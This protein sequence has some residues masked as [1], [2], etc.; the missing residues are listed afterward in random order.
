M[1]RPSHPV[2][3]AVMRTALAAALA[4]AG[5]VAWHGLAQRSGAGADAARA[6]S[7]GAAAPPPM[8][9]PVA[10]AQL[11]D[12]PETAEFT[13]HLAAVRSVE[14]RPRVGGVIEEVTL[15]EGGIVTPGQ[16]LFRID[17]RPY[18]AALLRAQAELAQVRERLALAE[19]QLGRTRT[20]SGQGWA[21]RERLDQ[22]T[23]ERDALRAGVAAAEAAV[24]SA[25]LDLEFTTITAPIGGRAGRALVTEG[26]LVAGAGPSPTLLTTIVSED[27]I[28]VMF[29]VDER[30]YLRLLARQAEAGDEAP[31]A[32]VGIGLA[33]EEGFPHRGRL[34][35]LDN[36]VDR[37][38]GTARL[39][40]V[41]PNPDGR[42]APGLFAR[43]ELVLAEPRPTVLVAER[44]IGA[45]QGRRYVLVVGADGRAQYRPVRLGP[46]VGDG[47]RVVREGL[48]PG[49]AV[50]ARGMIRPG[51]P[52]APIPAEQA[53]GAATTAREQRS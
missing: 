37:G 33:G 18:R 15:P 7:P 8:P 26:N 38:T 29:D 22:L 20:L 25:R 43:V 24:E 21:P 12:L 5:G 16:V 1:T 31:A 36:Q 10:A 35:F 9:V 32:E 4:A 53:G 42:L 11:R 14:L 6:A 44:A 39:R 28:H 27:P 40:A 51:T 17:P 34:D 50:I 47:L 30:I 49:E 41:V 45:D 48:A 46:A 19:V 23:A 3:K 13:G 2:R 52:V